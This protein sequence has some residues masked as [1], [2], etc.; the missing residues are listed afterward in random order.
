MTTLRHF[1]ARL[2]ALFR[3]GD[4]DRDFEQELQSHLEMLT[5]DNIRD[6]MA[7]GEARRQ[8]ALRLGAESS[9][10]SRHRDARGLPAFE[11]LLQDLRFACRLS[12]R[13]RWLSATIVGVLALGIGANTFGFAL[14][15]AAF[16]RG[17]PVP[18]SDRLVMVSWLDRDGRRDPASHVELL[19]W[20]QLTQF[21]GLADRKSVV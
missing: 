11:S 19:E 18:G 5:D 7:P 10:Q 12:I 15:N 21:E 14:V 17:L 16:W 1:V 3:G 4:L 8:A 6:G 20:Q 9:L 13:D 2:S